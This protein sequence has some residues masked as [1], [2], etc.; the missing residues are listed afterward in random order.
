MPP[1]NDAVASNL[2]CASAKRLGLDNDLEPQAT[3]S[4]I[5]RQLRDAGYLLDPATH[6]AVML[7]HGRPAGRGALSAG[8]SAAEEDRLRGELESLADQF[9]KIP[10]QDRDSQWNSLRERC[11]SHPALEFRLQH[12]AR[13]LRI[14]RT[15]YAGAA[16]AVARLVEDV[17]TLFVLRPIP[18]AARSRQLAARFLKDPKFTDRERARAKLSLTRRHPEIAALA[19]DYLDRLSPPRRSLQAAR[20][21]SS[22]ASAIAS[23][24]GAMSPSTT[25]AASVVGAVLVCAVLIGLGTVA[26]ISSE[27]KESAASARLRKALTVATPPEGTP[28]GAASVTFFR[29]EFKAP[30]ERE[31]EKVGKSINSTMLQKVVDALPE[32]LA[33]EQAG[34]GMRLLMGKWSQR[35]HD[36]SV[37]ALERGLK[38][39]DIDLTDDQIKAVARASVPQPST[40][41]ANARPAKPQ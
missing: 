1:G 18:R 37:A 24:P 20:R 3:R 38:D 9:F 8:E 10:V 33:T 32:E 25:I 30:V 16:P 22:F 29:N 36:L 13:G 17:L 41:S 11:A 31:L 26:S 34:L 12:L 28:P 6:E 14:D 35:D 21:R 5:L 2:L 19:D 39:A 15:S 40:R 23:P 4:A 27:R 7:L